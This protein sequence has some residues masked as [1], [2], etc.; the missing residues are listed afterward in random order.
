MLLAEVEVAA[1]STVVLSANIAKTKAWVFAPSTFKPRIL[2]MY[3]FIVLIHGL[4]LAYVTMTL[5]FGLE[6][7]PGR[8]SGSMGSRC[9]HVYSANVALTIPRLK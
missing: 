3:G 5:Y 6:V 9:S 2:V 4:V 8:W 7:W 1:D